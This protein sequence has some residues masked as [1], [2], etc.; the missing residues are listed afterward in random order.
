MS[1]IQN[2]KN[3]I[4][5]GKQA[6]AAQPAHGE[7]ATGVSNV[8]A[9]HSQH[10][11]HQK[12]QQKQQQQQQ[13]HNVGGTANAPQHHAHSEPNVDHHH[14]AKPLHADVL[15]ADYSVG[16]LDNRHVGARAADAAARAAGDHQKLHQPERQHQNQQN[17]KKN[18]GNA[19]AAEFDPTVLERIVAEE[20]E[21]Q[22]KLPRYPGLDRWILL[23]KMGDGAFSNV[24]RA[25]DGTG[26]V[27]EVAIKVVR[28][29]EMNATQV[30]LFFWPANLLFF[31]LCFIFV[32]DIFPVLL[33][34]NVHLLLSGVRKYAFRGSYARSRLSLC[35]A[36]K[37]SYP[38][39][40]QRAC[41]R[42]T[43]YSIQ[44]SRK[45]QRQRR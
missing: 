19:R 14:R 12:E 10:H 44:I 13:R 6:R 33:S 42:A 29:F 40:Q 26:R 24:Y 37:I 15:A 31:C 34:P 30:S 5:H 17:Q 21:S 16:A 27:G 39:Y 1:T 35:I 8:H 20:R 23:E 18:D 22:G 9:H 3:F 2:L 7:P 4:R 38:R 11:H 45:S 32:F 43:M 36:Y 28:K 41:C 25:K